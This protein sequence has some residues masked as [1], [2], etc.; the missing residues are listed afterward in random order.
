MF[1]VEVN[2]PVC[3]LVESTLIAD[4]TALRVELGR[5]LVALSQ[6][7]VA[8]R[9]A[10]VELVPAR[11]ARARFDVDLTLEHCTMLSER[12]I[13]RL[14]PWPGEPPGPDRPWLVTSQACAFLALSRR[15]RETAILRGD[16]NAL[17]R[18]TISWQAAHDVLDVDL[19]AAAD[20]G[21][22]APISSLAREVQSQWV[23]FWGPS[24][25][26]RIVGPQGGRNFPSVRLLYRP[27]PGRIEPADLILDRAYHPGRDRLDVGADLSLQGIVPRSAG[28]GTRRP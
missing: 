26:T 22:A 10:A 7:A 14:G 8:A 5:G 12:A 20:D 18:G 25:M 28:P 17:A 1:S 24:H 15:P 13:F 2:R 11:V 16:A 3:R 23:R 9:D 4:G 27:I 21:S 6:S 19:F